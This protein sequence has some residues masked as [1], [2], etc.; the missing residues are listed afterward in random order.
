MARNKTRFAAWSRQSGAFIAL[1]LARGTALFVGLYSLANTL[2]TSLSPGTSQDLWWIDTRFLPTAAAQALSVACALVLLA[3]GVSPRLATWRRWLTFVACVALAGVAL[4]NVATFYREWGAGSFSPG[5]VFP[6]S[7][8]IAVVFALLGWA[9]WGQRPGKLTVADH[10]GAVAGLLL[11]VLLFPLAQVAFFGSSDYRA[12]ADA[13]VVFGARVFDDGSLSPS[14]RDRVATGIELYRGGLVRKLVMSGGVEPNGQDE[15][16][17]MRS[18]AEKAGVPASAIVLDSKG[19]DTDATVRNTTA[20]FAK[21]GMRRVLAVSQGYHLPRVK[22][23]YL[24]AGWD[25]RTVPARQIE[26]IWQTPLFVA[27]EV[28]AFWEYWLRAFV[29]DARGTKAA[30]LL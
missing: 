8:V 10:V 21:Q 5:L 19:I 13:A 9:V 17:V 7:L 25:V 30:G 16:A 6:L 24:A 2:A 15:T 12:K 18:A 28:P 14:L 26:P 4:Q 29:R 3:F 20:I 27:R 22:L 23:A 11:V 1:A